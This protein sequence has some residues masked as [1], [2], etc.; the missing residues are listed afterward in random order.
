MLLDAFQ[1]KFL[2]THHVQSTV[3][4][5]EIP[6]TRAWLS[7]ASHAGRGGIVVTMWEENTP[8]MNFRREKLPARED[9]F[10]KMFHI[11]EDIWVGP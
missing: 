9:H 4:N 8:H 10:W 1:Q 5:T 7:R 6:G 11:H 2:Q 3:A